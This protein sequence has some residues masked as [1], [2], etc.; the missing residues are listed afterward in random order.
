MTITVN[1]NDSNW[2]NIDDA[3]PRDEE[4]VYFKCDYMCYEYITIGYLYRGDRGHSFWADND[5]FFRSAI[6]AWMPMSDTLD[7]VVC[8]EG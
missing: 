6:L 5:T 1:L 8:K 7:V 3:L 4:L 2:I